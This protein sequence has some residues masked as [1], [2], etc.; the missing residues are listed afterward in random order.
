MM[1]LTIEVA[2]SPEDI[3]TV[4]VLFREYAEGLPI[5][6]DFQGFD[7]EMATFPTGYDFLLLAKLE[8]NPIG[9]VACKPHSEGCCE[10]KR[11]F[12]RP[13]GLGKGIGRALSL[14][15]MKRAKGFGYASMVLDSLRRLEPAVKLYKSLGF[16]EI[17]PYN[18]NPEDDV[19][20]MKRDL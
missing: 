8:G 7:D 3:E 13:L 4:K 9:A 11:L 19:V 6:L 1:S 2:T 17:E 15:L 10:M 20:Y 18:F 16:T 14:D 12:V 5:P